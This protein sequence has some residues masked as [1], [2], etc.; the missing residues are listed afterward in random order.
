[1]SD[2][3]ACIRFHR[4][5]E[6]IGA[7]WSGVIVQ[8]MLD[9]HTRFGAI[10]TASGVSETMLARR[11]RDLQCEGIVERVVR[12]TTPVTVEY[13]LTDKGRELAPVFEAVGTWAHRWLSTDPEPTSDEHSAGDRLVSDQQ[14]QACDAP[15]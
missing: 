14:A 9:G 10:K 13:H 1:M 11:L 12:P 5:V 6:L 7:R 4:A 8:A 2:R 3:P 15:A